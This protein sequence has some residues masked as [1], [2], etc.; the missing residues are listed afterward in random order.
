MSDKRKGTWNWKLSAILLILG[1][2]ILNLSSTQMY[3]HASE[4]TTFK[5]E[6]ETSTGQ[7]GD[8]IT[9]AVNVYDAADLWAWQIEME[10]DPLVLD[11]VSITFGDFLAGQPDGTVN[12]ADETNVMYG[13]VLCTDT[14]LGSYPGADGDGWL[15]SLM[16]EVLSLVETTIDISSDWLW[17]YWIDSGLDY[18]GDDPGEMIK[19]NGY[20]APPWPEDI[21][22][23]GRV[24]VMDLAYVGINYGKSG[25]DINPPEADINGDSVVDI[26]D[27]SMV[28]IKYGQYAGY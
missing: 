25:G 24:D 3:G 15:V 16:F 27:L 23:D 19:E 11:Y 10:W 13:L 6:P 28:A 8:F 26:I 5:V 1:I 17:T 22:M 7:V 4:L 12:Y 18:W 21:N 2:V 14:T 9:V 20:F